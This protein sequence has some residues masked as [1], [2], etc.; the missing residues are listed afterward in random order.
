MT[1]YWVLCSTLTYFWR[2]MNISS[3]FYFSKSSSINTQYSSL[4]DTLKMMLFTIYLITRKRIGRISWKFRYWFNLR[5]SIELDIK[6]KMLYLSNAPLILHFVL[7][8][9]RINNN[10]KCNILM[11]AFSLRETT[12]AKSTKIILKIDKDQY[13][14]QF[15]YNSIQICCN[16]FQHWARLTPPIKC[17]I[18]DLYF[19]LVNLPETIRFNHKTTRTRQ[20][21]WSTAPPPHL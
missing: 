20:Q 5:S 18:F 11:L 17:N 12:Q 8:Y 1:E 10:T 2:N 21:R 4:W 6:R 9:I 13:A 16:T 14:Y 15:I 3:I 19:L 7:L